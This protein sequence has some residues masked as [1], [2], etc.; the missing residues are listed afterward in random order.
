MRR[1]VKAS[2]RVTLTAG[3]LDPE[4][5]LHGLDDSKHLKPERR[6]LLY[7][8]IQERPRY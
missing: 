4:D 6:E 1:G 5:P 2:V 8:S 3:I 7:Q